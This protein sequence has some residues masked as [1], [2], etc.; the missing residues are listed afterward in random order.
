[1][2]DFVI[3]GL[4]NPGAEHANDR[5]NAGFRVINLIAKRAHID[6]RNSKLASYG[7][8]RS[9]PGVLSMGK[10]SLANTSMAAAKSSAVR[11]RLPL[12]RSLVPISI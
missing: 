12:A 2:S 9:A 6:M 8:G 3:V 4:G 1:M 5:H 7:R 10:N 11:S